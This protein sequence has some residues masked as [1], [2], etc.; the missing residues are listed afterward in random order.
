MAVSTAATASATAMRIAR[1]SP[2]SDLHLSAL[3]LLAFAV[4]A[5]GLHVD[6]KSVV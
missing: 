3:L 5:G 4:A 2:L 6:R 1:R